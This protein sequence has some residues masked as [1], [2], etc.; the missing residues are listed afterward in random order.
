MDMSKIFMA[1]SDDRQGN[2]DKRNNQPQQ[3][4][5]DNDATES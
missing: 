4:E 3:D 5:K 1:M 2:A